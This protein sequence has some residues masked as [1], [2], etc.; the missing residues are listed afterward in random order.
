[1]KGLRT[2]RALARARGLF[3]GFWL[4]AFCLALALPASEA[5]G[6]VPLAGFLAG[7]QP[8]HALERFLLAAAPRA[9][10]LA[11]A[12]AAL[13]ALAGAFVLGRFHCSLL[14]PLGTCQDAAARLA[15]AGRSARRGPGRREGR[16]FG[17]ARPLAFALVLGGLAGGLPAA[18]ALLEPYSVF[19]RGFSRTAGDLAGL[20]LNGL[21]A[22]G[23]RIPVV[24]LRW[25][26]LAFALAALPFAA[27]LAAGSFRSRWFCGE[28]CPVGAALGAINRLAA[29]RVRFDPAACVSCGACEKVCRARCVDASGLDASRCV[30]CLDCLAA[31]PTGA[32][33]YGPAPAEGAGAPDLSRRRFIAEAGAVAAGAALALALPAAASASGLALVRKAPRGSSGRLLAAPPGAGSVDRYA[34]LC[35]GCGTCVRACPSGVLRHSGAEFGLARPMVP[36]LD[37]G[38]AFCQYE[39]VACAGVCPSGALLAVAPE[40]KKRTAVGKSDLVLADC[41]VVAKGTRCGACAEHC[42]SGAVRIEAVPGRPLPVPV[43]HAPTCV[44]CGACETVCPATPRKAMTVAGLAVHE[45][46]EPPRKDAPDGAAAPPVEGFAF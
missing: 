12:L 39:C 7:T 24:T 43:L 27:V 35:T 8:F 45:T 44:G 40:A 34:S 22:L 18:A 42:P 6:L 15:S 3:A 26:P 31:C 11:S 38:R 2:F 30:Q 17:V 5:P 10:V 41:I 9:A 16:A 21:E 4:A 46:A 32:L 23:L 20:A 29:L 19:A 14:C 13:A 1:M 28:L 36:Y 37:Y 25:E 33:S